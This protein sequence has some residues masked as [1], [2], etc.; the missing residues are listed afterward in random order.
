[1]ASLLV[2]V[3]SNVLNSSLLSNV[4]LLVSPPNTNIFSPIAA[5]A[6]PPRFEIIGTKVSQTSV[7]IL[8]TS[9]LF[10]FDC[11][12]PSLPPIT[13]ILF[14]IIADVKC[15]LGVGISF[16]LIQFSCSILY[17]SFIAV[18][19]TNVIPPIAKI[20]SSYI[21]AVRAPL[22]VGI[23]I[24]LFHESSIELYTYILAEGVQPFMYPPIT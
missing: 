7:F 5:A 22:A 19:P 14:S 23:S 18:V 24:P 4:D 3:F 13:N 17:I 11:K 8:Y 1:M 6:R 21:C 12:F 16:L 20:E 2:H 15:S 10:I 9:F